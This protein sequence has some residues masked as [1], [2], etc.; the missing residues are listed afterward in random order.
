M[1][2]PV[3]AKVEEIWL[4]NISWT[5]KNCDPEFCQEA[6]TSLHTGGEKETSE[7]IKLEV[8]LKP[9]GDK[10]LADL[11]IALWVGGGGVHESDRYTFRENCISHG[12]IG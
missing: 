2:P 8:C 9:I 4:Q 3:D 7:I 10:E 12:D 6:N 5:L 11:I 1:V